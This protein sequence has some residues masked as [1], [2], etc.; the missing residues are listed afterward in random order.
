MGGV[1]MPHKLIEAAKEAVKMAG[2]P[3]THAYKKSAHRLEWDVWHCP[4]CGATMHVPVVI[5]PPSP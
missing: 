1:L 5:S 4:D 2:C 3:H